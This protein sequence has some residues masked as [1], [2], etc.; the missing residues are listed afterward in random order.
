MEK[1]GGLTENMINITVSVDADT[2]RPV[3]VRTTALP[4]SGKR[5]WM[6]Q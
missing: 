4:R 5:A 3:R 6:A 2:R 1:I